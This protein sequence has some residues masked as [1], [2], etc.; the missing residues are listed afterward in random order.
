MIFAIGSLSCSLCVAI[1]IVFHILVK[2]GLP[3]LG[4]VLILTRISHGWTLSP[5]AGV[6]LCCQQEWLMRVC[7]TES[8]LWS[9]VQGICGTVG[10][11]KHTSEQP[12]IW[13]SL[14]Q[15]E[16]DIK[17]DREAMLLSGNQMLFIFQVLIAIWELDFVYKESWLGSEL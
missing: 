15:H 14:R 13:P 11:D 9:I 10:G 3:H 6:P 5:D 17:L 2:N 7:P 16:K 1:V 4:L 8:S 12:I